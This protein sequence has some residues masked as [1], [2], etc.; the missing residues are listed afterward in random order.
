MHIKKIPIYSDG[1]TDAQMDQSLMLSQHSN[2]VMV[3]NGR[4]IQ[5]RINNSMVP[6]FVMTVDHPP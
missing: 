1:I 6:N 3:Y 4:Y 5:K 2:K